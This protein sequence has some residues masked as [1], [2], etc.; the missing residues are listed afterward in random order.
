MEASPDCVH[1]FSADSDKRMFGIETAGDT[2]HAFHD[3]PLLRSIGEIDGGFALYNFATLGARIDA[4]ANNRGSGDGWH[5]DAFGYQFKAIVYLCD[6]T[7]ENGPFE[8]VIGSQKTWQVGLDCGLGRFPVP[9]ESRIARER[10]DKLI[11]T[12]TIAPRRFTA[13]AGTV[14][15][16]NTTGVHR[17]APL[18]SGKRYAMTNYYYNS[19]QIGETLLEKFEP[20][21][22]GARQRLA[23]LIASDQKSAG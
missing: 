2:C 22:P 5:R 7:D 8:Y 1:R 19:Y 18:L 10:V 17:G 21:V 11:A 6:V 23:K 9:P 3:D 12:G 16:A 4:T 15:L 20:L 13:K 14:I